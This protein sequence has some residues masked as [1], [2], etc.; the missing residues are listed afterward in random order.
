MSPKLPVDLA[1]ARGKHLLAALS[2]GADSTALLTLLVESRADIGFELT[3][4]H[5]NHGLRGEDSQADEDFC[6]ALCQK[7]RVPL[8]VRRVTV[9]RRT[10]EGGVESAAREARYAALRSIR[11]EVGADWIALAHHR[12]DQAETVLMHLL[13]GC[14]TDGA[15]GMRALSDDLYRPLLGVSRRELEDWL[16]ACGIDWREDA[17]NALPFTP[18]NRIRMEALPLLGDIYPGAEDA[19]CR[20][21]ESAAVDADA[22]DAMAEDWQRG[23]LELGPFSCR[24]TGVESAPEAILRRVI[25]NLCRNSLSSGR[26]R[27]IAALCRVP[28]GRLDAGGF[29]TAE[30]VPGALYLSSPLPELPEL[31]LPLEGTVEYAGLGR[32][33]IAPHPA[34]PVRDDRLCQVV[35]AE[36]LEGCVLRTRRD[37]DRMRPLGCGD[38]LLSDVLTDRKIDRP[39]RDTLPL[40]AKGNRVYWAIGVGLAEEAKLA[41]ST[42]RAAVLRWTYIPEGTPDGFSPIG[43]A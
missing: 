40:V 34:E 22:L 10:G 41:P 16:R 31:P 12:D 36:C 17:T 27:A 13:R 42:R 19:L 2:G 32:L 30:K 23:H 28:R 8:M 11:R 25:R 35:D 14:G 21:A 7:L 39:L 3:A 1:P 9:R 6:R 38:R 18:R 4:A 37:G 24:L 20:F 15:A 5:I 29:L 26:V 43:N 33:S